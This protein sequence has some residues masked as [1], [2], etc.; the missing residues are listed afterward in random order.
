MA[1][2]GPDGKPS[3]DSA[4][5]AEAATAIDA[6]Y[7][8]GD[9]SIGGGSWVKGA[10]DIV[11]NDP[12]NTEVTADHNAIIT[13]TADAQ[14]ALAKSLQSVKLGVESGTL[15]SLKA[16]IY[17]GTAAWMEATNNSM[18]VCGGGNSEYSAV[19]TSTQNCLK[20]LDLS[21]SGFTNVTGKIN[22]LANGAALNMNVI[23]GANISTGNGIKHK[24]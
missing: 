15:E 2:D 14:S 11:A 9:N 10:T 22:Q 4:T 12:V 18:T 21:G 23:S 16:A 1:C 3:I 19:V 13:G 17:G 8:F 20:G 6:I 24:K 5:S 7:T